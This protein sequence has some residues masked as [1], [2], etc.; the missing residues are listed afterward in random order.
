MKLVFF[1]ALFALTI[2]CNKKQEVYLS[3]EQQHKKAKNDFNNNKFIYFDYLQSNNYFDRKLY[4]RLLQENNITLDTLIPE[5]CIPLSTTDL[6]NEHCYI[7][8]MNNNLNAKFG[9]RFFDSLRLKATIKN[10]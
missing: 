7:Q 1:F 10:N 4:S 8:M 6:N 9:H 3:C 2:S 5:R